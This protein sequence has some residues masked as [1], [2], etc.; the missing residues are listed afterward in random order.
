MN[1]L[2]LKSDF[3]FSMNV[4]DIFYLALVI[5]KK[6]ARCSIN[7]YKEIVSFR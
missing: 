3:Y 4:A 5:E 1:K 7:D 2:M 6:R